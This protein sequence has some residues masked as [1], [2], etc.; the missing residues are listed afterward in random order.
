[1]IDL[2]AAHLLPR[3]SRAPSARGYRLDRP[4]FVAESNG[5]TASYMHRDVGS[6]ITRKSERSCF[7]LW[8]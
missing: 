2:L 3:L 4:H 5:V 7:F 1:M 6:V 8:L